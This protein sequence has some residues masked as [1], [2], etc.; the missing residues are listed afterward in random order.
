MLLDIKTHIFFFFRLKKNVVQDCEF[1][2]SFIFNLANYL[3]T[4]LTAFDHI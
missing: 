2:I 4:L 1:E 3:F